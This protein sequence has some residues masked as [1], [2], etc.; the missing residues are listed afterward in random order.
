MSKGYYETC[1][2]PKPGNK[3]K[4]ILY[5]GYKNKAERVC[6]FCKTPNAERHEVF[7]G[8]NRQISIREGFQVDLCPACHAEMQNNITPRGQARNKAFRIHFQKR[9][10]DKLINAGTD[11]EKAR[12]LWIEMM[13][14]NYR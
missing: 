12:E 11:P 14:R 2:I 13:G 7:P 6:F 8:N 3:K 4:K 5:N 9:W 1:A 10:E